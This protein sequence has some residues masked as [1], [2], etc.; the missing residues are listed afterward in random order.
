[1]E[2]WADKAKDPVERRT[3]ERLTEKLDELSCAV[4]IFMRS[5]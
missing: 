4:D 3:V 1:M 5:L 2:L